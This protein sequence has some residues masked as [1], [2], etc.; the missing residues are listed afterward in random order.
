MTKSEILWRVFL[1][2][3]RRNKI[4][5]LNAPKA[6][7]RHAEGLLKERWRQ[8]NDMGLSEKDLIPLLG[9][10]GR[11]KAKQDLED[12]YKE[13]CLHHLYEL[14]RCCETDRNPGRPC[15]MGQY[16][17]CGPSCPHFR[18]ASRDEDGQILAEAEYGVDQRKSQRS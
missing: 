5:G 13:D 10:F 9:K 17:D 6:I 11:L 7:L 15:L 12:S 4:R 16:E 8:A 1:A 18:E 14:L 3:A 2:D